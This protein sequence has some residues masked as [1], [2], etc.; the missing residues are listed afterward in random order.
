MG[1]V[2]FFLIQSTLLHSKTL[3]RR[4]QYMIEK[5]WEFLAGKLRA[6]LRPMV[7]ENWGVYP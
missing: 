4:V 3:Q 2:R 5:I 6:L 1:E 7:Y